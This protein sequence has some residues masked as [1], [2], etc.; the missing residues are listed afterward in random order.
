M[1][2]TTNTAV[3]W[4]VLSGTSATVSAAGLV[5]ASN[6][7]QGVTTVQ[8]QSQADPNAKDV[9]T[10][11]VGPASGGGATQVTIGAVT[12]FGTIFPVNPGNVFGIIDITANL[13]VPTGTTGSI[14]F[15][16]VDPAGNVIR[17]DI[18][19]QQFTSGSSA[20]TAIEAV[21]VTVVCTFNTAS[22]DSAGLALLQNGT[23][24]IRV[25]VLNAAGTTQLATATGQPLVFNNADIAVMTVRTDSMTGPQTDQAGLSWRAGQV[26][27]HVRPAIFTNTQASPLGSI[28][29][30]N[31]Y[32]VLE[33]S[34]C[35]L[36]RNRPMLG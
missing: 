22:L 26:I 9:V 15:D 11:T 21:P 34:G 17:A 10:I 4:S 1:A 16:I 32:A 13:D 24:R 31:V 27:V 30:M 19:S 29:S 23:Y 18:C 14:R 8:A 36:V 33:R 6:T 2:N 25:R 3:T 28:T 7:V 20:E 5:T 12:Q 35:E